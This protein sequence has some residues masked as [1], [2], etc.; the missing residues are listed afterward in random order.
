MK[1][2]STFQT[3][4][5]YDGEYWR[6]RMMSERTSRPWQ[7]LWFSSLSL[8]VARLVQ[9]HPI[10]YAGLLNVLATQTP[11]F[12]LSKDWSC[13]CLLP[14]VRSS[15]LLWAIL[16]AKL[17]GIDAILDIVKYL[18]KHRTFIRD[19]ST[20][21]AADLG[22]QLDQH[23]FELHVYAGEIISDRGPVVISLAFSDFFSLHGV[24]ECIG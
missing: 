19:N 17:R 11:T 18:S 22:D 13:L 9:I 20:N 14:L 8:I 15:C 4:T 7:D 16:S 5:V 23:V 12:I 3:V 6:R 21:T 1:P 2:K 24:R 10:L